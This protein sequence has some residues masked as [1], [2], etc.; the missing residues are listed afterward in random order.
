MR[1]YDCK[2]CILVHENLN[3][4]CPFLY[5]HVT[6]SSSLKSN[7]NTL[8]FNQPMEKVESSKLLT[9]FQP[10]HSAEFDTEPNRFK[11]SLMELKDLS[12]QLYRAADYCEK[13]FL[14][15]NQ[16][17]TLLENTKSYVCEVIV[18]VVDHLG[19][20]SSNIEQRF[21]TYNN[22]S[23]TEHR[24]NCLRQRI[25]SCQQYTFG[26]DISSLLLSAKFSRHQCRYV[27]PATS[28]NLQKAEKVGEPSG[29]DPVDDDKGTCLGITDQCE[30]VTTQLPFDANTVIKPQIVTEFN[31][32]AELST[33]VPVLKLS[34]SLKQFNTSSFDF[35]TEN[36]LMPG[37]GNHKKRSSSGRRILSFLRNRKPSE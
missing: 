1:I 18:T 9:Q 16:K 29:V 26:L 19:T 35:L 32:G 21:N 6:S 25:L 22:A 37:S 36:A 31:T 30:I 33:K 2:L 13:S 23:R 11:Q 24:I 15:T 28:T 4:N 34:R 12:S 14:K 17:K 5:A 10:Y 20:V 7:I 27:L 8:Y 3:I